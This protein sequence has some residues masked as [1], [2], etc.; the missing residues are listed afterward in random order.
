MWKLQQSN[1]EVTTCYNNMMAVWLKL[2]LF[3]DKQQ[4]NSND[5]AQYHKNVERGWVFVFLVDLNKEL[6]EV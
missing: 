4:E 5:S 6:D 2:D 1:R 3:K